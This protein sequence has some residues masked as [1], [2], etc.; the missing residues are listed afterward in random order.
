[1]HI[2]ISRKDILT[3]L[4]I[5]NLSTIVTEM[6]VA[7]SWFKSFLVKVFAIVLEWER[8]TTMAILIAKRAIII[9]LAI[10]NGS[11]ELIQKLKQ[12]YIMS[13]NFMYLYSRAPGTLPSGAHTE[14][15]LEHQVHYLV[16]LTL[17]HV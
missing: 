5:K 16:V 7:L 10:Q 3:G 15:C 11:K 13:Y 12:I 2:T 1:M 8:A 9:D 17:N 6:V 14:P 4:L